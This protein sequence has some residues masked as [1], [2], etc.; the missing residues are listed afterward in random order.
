M[1]DG[2]I[3]G[4]SPMPERLPCNAPS[5]PNLEP[6]PGGSLYVMPPANYFDQHTQDPRE[7][8]N[9]Y[10]QGKQ[11]RVSTVAETWF[12]CSKSLGSNTDALVCFP[13]QF[14][15]TNPC[16]RCRLDEASLIC[17]AHDPASIPDFIFQ[18]MGSTSEHMIIQFS[19]Y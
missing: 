11:D 4:K 16:S 2:S 5:F 3:T 15:N 19:T 18:M 8:F 14:M 7:L 9:V 17:I 13:F 6:P 10:V 1:R 12:Y